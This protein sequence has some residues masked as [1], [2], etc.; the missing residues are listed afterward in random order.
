MHAEKKMRTA[1]QENTAIFEQFQELTQKIK[2][3][4]RQ[5]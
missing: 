1:I 2:S 5:R 3:R 4:A